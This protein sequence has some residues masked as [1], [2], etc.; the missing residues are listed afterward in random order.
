MTEATAATVP[1]QSVPASKPAKSRYVAFPAYDW[2]FFIGSPI[3][4]LLV[5]EALPLWDYAF[6]QTEA[7]GG[8]NLRVVL[9]ITMFTTAHLTAVVFRSHGNKEIFQRHPI[10]FTVVPALLFL[11]LLS[12]VW[13]LVTAF[14]IAFFWDV[15]HSSMQNFGLCRIY[16]AKEG[17]SRDAGRKMDYWMNHVL[18]MGPILAG[19]SLIAHFET[20]LDY[21]DKVSWEGAAAV[22]S[23][24]AEYRT[25]I[26]WVTI[27]ACSGFLVA[28]LAFYYRLWRNGHKI[29][30]NKVAMLASVGTSS[31]LAWG[32]L[33]P[34]EAFFVVNLYHAVQYFAIVWWMEKKNMAKLFR[35]S[36][37]RYGM[38]LAIGAY[39]GL[40]FLMGMSCEM[41]VNSELHWAG[42]AVI[43]V[44]LM[45]F[46][47]DGFI[48]SVRKRDV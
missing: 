13:L 41:G 3:L 27:A 32:F 44:T 1:A 36:R 40:V 2:L 22:V 25:P 20:P 37:F 15:Y 16:D 48:W 7:F 6:E 4:A 18:Y 38:W 12:S 17:N 31:T 21:Y 10:R 42:A 46:W 39:I 30:V 8:K 35:V 28:Y 19:L 29:S 34:I 14:V 26:R 45:H 9:F 43:V 24:V 11:T 47:Y 33:P 5:A 23:T